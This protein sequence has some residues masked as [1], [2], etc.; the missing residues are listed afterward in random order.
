MEIVGA[1]LVLEGI[2]VSRQEGRKWGSEIATASS[3]VLGEFSESYPHLPVKFPS[4]VTHVFF[5]LLLLSFI[6]V[7]LVVVL[8][9]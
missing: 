4:C 5:K 1:T 9:L 3:F 2:C 7:G 8:S 6:S